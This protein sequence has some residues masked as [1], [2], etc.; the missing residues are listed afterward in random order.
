LCV[1]YVGTQCKVL[2]LDENIDET[3]FQVA[4]I[5]GK[6]QLITP[7]GLALTAARNQ[8]IFLIPTF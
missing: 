1:I 3:P 6:K 7:L 5:D 8:V 2:K 4:T